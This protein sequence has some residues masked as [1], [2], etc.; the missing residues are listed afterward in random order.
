MEMLDFFAQA[1][2]KGPVLLKILVVEI[3][4]FT[5]MSRIKYLQ[6]VHLV[7]LATVFFLILLYFEHAQ[8]H[9]NITQCSTM[10]TLLEL[11]DIV[12]FVSLVWSLIIII[13]K[14]QRVVGCI[15]PPTFVKIWLTVSMLVCV[16]DRW[17]NKWTKVCSVFHPS[18]SLKQYLTQS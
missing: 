16:R 12:C 3:I 6:R 7:F 2:L 9:N 5:L 13:W 11:I 18:V 8:S 1:P 17:V 4:S 14:C 10:V 15:I